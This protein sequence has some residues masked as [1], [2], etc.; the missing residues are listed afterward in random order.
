[1]NQ[2]FLQHWKLFKDCG[3]VATQNWAIY[4]DLPSDY[5]ALNL[6]CKVIEDP[7]NSVVKEILAH[8]P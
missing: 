3:A 7:E 1:M 2:I 5:R 8:L 6:R 4:W